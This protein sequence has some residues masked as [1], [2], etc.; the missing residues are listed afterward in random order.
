MNLP[1]N[2]TGEGS[3]GVQT[4]DRNLLEEY[5]LLLA[6]AIASLIGLLR[7]RKWFEEQ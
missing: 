7:K 1:N 6:A 5:L 2:G 4:S 3:A